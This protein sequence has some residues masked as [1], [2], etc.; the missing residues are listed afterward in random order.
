MLKRQPGTRLLRITTMASWERADR[1]HVGNVREQKPPKKEKAKEF[2]SLAARPTIWSFPLFDS[3]IH[4]C[5]VEV[6]ARSSRRRH[7]RPFTSATMRREWLHA[8][9]VSSITA[10]SGAKAQWLQARYSCQHSLRIK[11][12]VTLAAKQKGV[13]VRWKKIHSIHIV[14]LHRQVSS[15]LCRK[16]C[17]SNSIIRINSTVWLTIDWW[18]WPPTQPLGFLNG[19]SQTK[20]S[21]GD[22]VHLYIQSVM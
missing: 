10:S 9:L 14:P 13:Q 22:P 1:T 19:C 12:W 6:V 3:Q 17:C 8:G 7:S 15:R 16:V 5:L 4:W 21:Y 11:S 18:R 2:S 20:L